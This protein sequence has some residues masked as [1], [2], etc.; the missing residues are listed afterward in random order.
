[1]TYVSAISS[2]V[3]CESL[4]DALRAEFGAVLAA[5]IIGGRGAR[6]PVGWARFG[7]LSGAAFRVGFRTWGRWRK[8]AF[9]GRDLELFRWRVAR[10]GV[11]GRWRRGGRGAALAA[12][13]RGARGSAGGVRSRSLTAPDGNRFRGA[14]RW[15]RSLSFCSTASLS[16]RPWTSGGRRRR[17]EAGRAK[18]EGLFLRSASA[19]VCRSRT[20]L[21]RETARPGESRMSRRSANGQFLA[22]QACGSQGLRRAIG[23]RITCGGGSRCV[24]RCS[25]WCRDRAPAECRPGARMDDHRIRAEDPGACAQADRRARAQ[26]PRRCRLAAP[27]M[28]AG[29]ANGSGPAQVRRQPDRAWRGR[30]GRRSPSRDPHG[31]AA[32]AARKDRQDAPGAACGQGDRPRPRLH[33]QAISSATAEV[34]GTAGG[35]RA[36]CA[37]EDRRTA[38]PSSHLVRWRS[39]TSSGSYRL[40]RGRLRLRGPAAR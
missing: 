34:P 11:R 15:R 21:L 5:R 40:G 9:A 29:L 27:P 24:G 36:L 14:A 17:K 23:R 33:F 25:C 39:A 31:E 3:S 32:R 2:V 4:V 8:R 30:P 1:M 20:S 37:H 13:A 26:V 38:R 7:A 18:I 35:S 10:G 22:L 6:F 16:G 28:Q 19:Q 12:A